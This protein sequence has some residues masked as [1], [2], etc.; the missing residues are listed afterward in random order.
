MKSTLLYILLPAL[1]LMGACTTQ[2]KIASFANK[3]LVG[4]SIFK[5]SH[6]GIS[7]HD[8]E[9]QK[10]IYAYQSSKLFTPASNTKILSC[11]AAM[12]YL[13]AF[14][15][16]A[17]LTNLD[18]AV[19]I[20]PTG[21]PS[22]LQ[23]DFNSHPLFDKLKAI[24]KP[25]YI[26]INNW[27]TPAL[28]LGWSWND[29]SEYYMTE[30]SSFPVYG[31]QIHWYQEKGKKDNPT[32]LGDTVDLFI[33]SNPEVNWP[34]KFGTG[35]SNAFYVERAKEENSFTLNEGKEKSAMESVP[36]I[37][38]GIETGLKLLKDSLGKEIQLADEGMLLMGKKIK[39]DTIY[40]HPTDTLLKIMM[41]RSDNFYA[42]QCLAMVGQQRFQVM[43]EQELIREMLTNELAGLPQ[44]P[45]WVDGSGL[46]RY[47]LFSPDDMVYIL[48]K[49]KK[50]QPWER[51]KTI[52]P[53]AG[54]GTLAMYKSNNEVYIYAKTGSLGGVVALS[55]YLYTQK[56]KWL[57]FSIMINNTKAPNAKIRNQINEFLLKTAALY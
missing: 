11:Y 5:Q 1:F 12:K 23:P 33:Y 30:R 31:N 19:L 6:L 28:G 4:D 55:G 13:P 9:T 44:K 43:D 10:N 15:P 8:P 27:K 34:V 37:T 48:G 22:F 39:A 42:D 57:I 14:L 52:F 25:L 49:I 7:I 36:Y 21:D 3:Y 50:E 18:T 32:Y 16:A 53:K 20:T 26:Q 24:N 46:S 40:S 35:V 38:K 45:T 51:I 17:Y 54:E 2:K 47:N 29:Y 41:H 56:K